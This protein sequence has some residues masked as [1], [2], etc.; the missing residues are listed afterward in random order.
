MQS[1]VDFC[2]HAGLLQHANVP[3]RSNNI[4]DL[5][6]SH[7]NLPVNFLFNVSVNMPTA[8]SDHSLIS[9]KLACFSITDINLDRPY[10]FHFKKCTISFSA[11][12][13]SNI[14]WS[15]VFTNCIG[16]DDLWS[17][18]TKNV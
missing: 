11:Y 14:D 17:V 7:I 2:V 8:Q 13:L 15:V 5:I 9:F 1:F 16:I 12:M 18:F 4:I 6:L 10:M 3:T